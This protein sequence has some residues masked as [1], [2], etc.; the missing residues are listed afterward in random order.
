MKSLFF[1]LLCLPSLLIANN[2]NDSTSYWKIH[3]QPML[4]FNQAHYDNWAAGG[5]N[6]IALSTSIDFRADYKQEDWTFN[7]AYNQN[8]GVANI[9]EEDGVIKTQDILSLL[10]R[11]GKR[12][13]ENTQITFFTDVLTQA[14]PTYYEVDE[15]DPMRAKQSNFFAPGYLTTGFGLEYHSDSLTVHADIS[16]VA[17]KQTIVMDDEVDETNYGIEE[18]KMMRNE[19][20]AYLRLSYEKE[21]LDRTE[22]STH[23]LVFTNYLEDFGTLDLYWRGRLNIHANDWLAMSLQTQLIFDKDV[24]LDYLKDVNG[25]GTSDITESDSNLQF[26]QMLG[27]GAT[28]KF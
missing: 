21:I 20:G 17:G 8:F 7:T 2:G 6:S 1:E 27:L 22:L 9:A 24:D 11:V 25:D 14:S 15:T 12:Q 5:R 16:P 4:Q 18:G 3:F 28:I 23:L 10:T 13:G 26:M 19:L